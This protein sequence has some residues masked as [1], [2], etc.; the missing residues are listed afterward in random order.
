M[1]GKKTF[2]LG[3]VLKDVLTPDTAAQEQIV[4]I[5]LSF[6]VSD[7]RNFYS[8]DGVDELAANIATVGLQQPLRVLKGENGFYV[9]VSGHRRAAALRILAEDAPE[10]WSRVPC[11]VEQPAASPELE[12][13]RLIFANADTRKMSSVD[14][15]RQAERVEEL[16]YKLQEQGYEFPGRMRDHVAA[17]CKVSATKI[18]TLKAIKSNL[19]KPLYEKYYETG[20]ISETVAYD[21]SKQ[22]VDL[23]RRICDGWLKTHPRLDNIT[24]GFVESYAECAEKFAKIKCPLQDGLTCTNCQKML[25]KVFANNYSYTACRYNNICCAKCHDYLNCKGRC[26]LLDD[27]AKA[28]RA[29]KREASAAERAEQKRKAEGTILTIDRAWG[30]FGDA[31]RRKGMTDKEL[32]RSVKPKDSCYNPAETYLGDKMVEALLDGS[33]TEVKESTCTP[34]G[35]DFKADDFEKVVRIADAL[36]V[37]LDYLFLRDDKPQ[38]EPAPPEWISVDDRYP[39]EGAFVIAATRSNVAV[40][41]VYFRAAFMDFTEKSVANNRI[42]GVEWWAPLPKLPDGKKWIG[43]ETIEGMVKK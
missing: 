27:K 31:L 10:K 16:L 26:P 41:A 28:E 32:R 36:D 39:D 14:K 21:L 35:H 24:F 34:F 42:Q 15:A 12:E 9:I 25:D 29:K 5:E 8:M 17:A 1:A 38:P 37:S 18:A 20:K 43:Q 11:I 40:P 3:D 23:Q 2:D 13:L 19:D 22:P 7:E 30:R 6:L 4:Y 33:C